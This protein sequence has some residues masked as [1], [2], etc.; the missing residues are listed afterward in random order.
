MKCQRPGCTRNQLAGTGYCRP[1]AFTD[2]HLQHRVDAA[3]IRTH[4]QACIDQ[5]ATCTSI[6]KQCGVGHHTVSD[7]VSGKRTKIRAVTARKLAAASPNM[8]AWVPSWPIRRRLQSLRAAG[9]EIQPL[10]QAIGMNKQ[11][12]IDLCANQDTMDANLAQRIRVFY[13]HHPEIIGPPSWQTALTTWPVP[14]TWDNIDNPDEHH[15][16]DLTAI[17]PAVID[18]LN[19]LRAQTTSWGSV[20][21]QLGIVRSHLNNIRR[22]DQMR[23]TLDLRRRIFRETRR[24]KQAA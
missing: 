7:I 10:A 1:H 5:G 2:G 4:L 21:E 13:D 12:I 16:D 18:A 3:T 11:T 15:G 24:A 19:T 17:T 23:I 22:R 14:M 9:W 20:A 6:A 8:A